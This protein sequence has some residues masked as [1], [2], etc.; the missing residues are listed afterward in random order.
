MQLCYGTWCIGGMWD[1]ILVRRRPHLSLFLEF[2][3]AEHIFPGNFGFLPFA[4]FSPLSI[5]LALS[6]GFLMWLVHF[7]EGIMITSD[8]WNDVVWQRF[9]EI[10][11]R[12]FRL[13][14]MSTLTIG[15]QMPLTF[16][17]QRLSS[18][19]MKA[20]IKGLYIISSLFCLNA[21]LQCWGALSSEGLESVSY[22]SHKQ[23]CSDGTQ[24]V[25]SYTS[26]PSW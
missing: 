11:I 22:V 9:W 20:S 7:L 24:W 1:S 4:P 21:Q 25:S 5:Q 16:T 23:G 12:L 15:S 10:T 13:N 19:A 17:S 3:C 26:L 8:L 6:V 18:A 2:D 14:I